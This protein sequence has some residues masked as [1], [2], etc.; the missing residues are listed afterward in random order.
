MNKI[1][2][3][4][5]LMVFMGA[6][7]VLSGVIKLNAVRPI[8]KTLE[9]TEYHAAFIVN[10]SSLDY[11]FEADDDRP[12][13]LAKTFFASV[14]SILSKNKVSSEE[15]AT[16]IVLKDK[17][18]IFKFAGIAEYHANENPDEPGN[19]SLTMTFNEDDIVDIEKK[20]AVNKLLCSD[21]QFNDI[22]TNLAYD[23]GWMNMRHSK[24][25]LDACLLVIETILQILDREANPS[26]TV[27]LELPGYFVASV[28]VEADEK[29]FAITPEGHMKAIVK[30][31]GALSALID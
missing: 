22:F 5:D 1:L 27:D 31:D 14:A 26:E 8:N 29:I 3:N 13:S 9:D 15:K 24:Y 25:V 11:D 20:K 7:D 16:A 10:G 30:D 21:A 12:E 23:I 4:R 28:A 6:S 19:W 18:G 2:T 17:H